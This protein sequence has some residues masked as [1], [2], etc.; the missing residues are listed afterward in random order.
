MIPTCGVSQNQ[1]TNSCRNRMEVNYEKD[2]IHKRHGSYV[3]SM[4]RAKLGLFCATV[5]Q[6]ANEIREEN[7]TDFDTCQGSVSVFAKKSSVSACLCF[8][9]FGALI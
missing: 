3:T 6:V 9:Q 2:L 5:H 8:F 7:F 4:V 1:T